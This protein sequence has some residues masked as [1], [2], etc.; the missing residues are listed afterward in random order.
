MRWERVEPRE[1]EQKLSQK[2]GCDT[3][4]AKRYHSWERRQ[5]ENANGL[6]RQRFPK[7]ILETFA[8]A[9]CYLP[10]SWM[11]LNLCLLWSI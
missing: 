11:E 8:L 9:I 2:L 1:I 10:R 3:Y 7:T 4:F 5:N 6:L